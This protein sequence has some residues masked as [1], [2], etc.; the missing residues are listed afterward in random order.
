MIKIQ[1]KSI[2]GTIL[3]EYEKENNTIKDTLEEA[4]KQN[5]NLQNA[6]LYNANLENAYLENAYLQNANLENAYLQNANLYNA[7]L[8]NANLYNANLENAYLQ[9]AYLPMWCKWSIGIVNGKIKI[10]CKEK[11]I[12]EWDNWFSGTQEYST[13]RGTND[14][15]Q[16]QAMYL[17]FKAYQEFLNTK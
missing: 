14:F 15:K 17:G 7:N 3:F 2:I 5:A 13:Q 16:I 8:E 10:G 9:N 1:I 11:T 6:N 12:E 4:I